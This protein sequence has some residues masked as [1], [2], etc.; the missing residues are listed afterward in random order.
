MTAPDW[1]ERN[2]RR[3]DRLEP[4]LDGDIAFYVGLAGRW[5]PPVLELGCGTGRVT[6]AIAD[7]GIPIVGLDRSAAMLREA[8]CKAGTRRDVDWILADMRSFALRRRFGLI[9]IPFRS[10]MHLLTCDDQR[11]VL[12]CVH[13]HLEAGGV[14]ALNIFNRPRLGPGERSSVVRSQPAGGDAYRGRPI[15]FTEADDMRALLERAGFAVEA[16]YGWFDGRPY[17]PDSTEQ[18]WVVRRIRQAGRDGLHV[19]Q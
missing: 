16:L 8:R 13:D 14:L 3:Y 4:G 1:Y 5:A 18:M 17:G 19:G 10:F 11:A 7:A 9:V 12:R 6:L 15:R 2:A